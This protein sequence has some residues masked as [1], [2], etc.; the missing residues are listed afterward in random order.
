M[1]KMPGIEMVSFDVDGT[2]I[3]NGFNDLIWRL[4]I[5]W[6]YAQRKKI[7][8][9]EAKRTVE[10]EYNRVGEKDS[11]WYDINFWIEHFQLCVS[12]EEIICKYEP[13]IELYPDAIP[14]LEK[15]RKKY[16]LIVI[17]MMPSEFL[18]PKLSKIGNYFEYAFSTISEFKDFKSPRGYLRICKKLRIPPSHLLHIGD[19]WEFDYISPRQVNINAVLIDRRSEREG[20]WIIKDLRELEKII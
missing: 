16:P 12:W 10:E 19:H 8:F 15:L 11:R 5:P 14:V 7:S 1:Q 9:E 13:R 18:T 20:K 4:E 17:S 3:K 2:L 6:L